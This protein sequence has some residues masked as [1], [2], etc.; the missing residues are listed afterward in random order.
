MFYIPFIGKKLQENDEKS[1]VYFDFQNMNFLYLVHHNVNSFSSSSVLLT[2]YTKKPSTYTSTK[3][4]KQNKN[5]GSN[6]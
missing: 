3:K 5:K 4:T 1:F 2:G 6:E